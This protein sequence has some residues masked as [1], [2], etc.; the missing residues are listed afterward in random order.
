MGRIFFA[1]LITLHFLHLYFKSNY[2]SNPKD[3]ILVCKEQNGQAFLEYVFLML[4]TF[5]LAY[6]FMGLSNRAFSARWVKIVNKVIAP[7]S[8]SFR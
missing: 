8:V 6:T 2:L 1:P 5:A 3:N 7:Y 4:I